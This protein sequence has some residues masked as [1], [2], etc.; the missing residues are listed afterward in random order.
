MIH[1]IW[2]Q[3]KRAW[4]FDH[5]GVGAERD[6]HLVHD[7][8]RVVASSHRDLQRTQKTSYQLYENHLANYSTCGILHA[9]ATSDFNV[10]G[11]RM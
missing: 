2:K 10:H 3:R 4:R 6:Q 8:E 9:L 1:L 11:E 7:A 5:C